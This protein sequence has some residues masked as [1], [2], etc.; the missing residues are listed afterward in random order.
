MKTTRTFASVCLTASCIAFAL[1]ANVSVGDQ[2]GVFRMTVAPDD[3]TTGDSRPELLTSP[4]GDLA[5]SNGGEPAGQIKL[6]NGSGFTGQL[7]GSAPGEVTLNGGNGPVFMDAGQFIAQSNGVTGQIVGS[8]AFHPHQLFGPQLTFE[9]NIDD[10]LGMPNSFTRFNAFIPNHLVDNTTILAATVSASLTDEGDDLYNYGAIL[11]HFDQS[12]N[13][14]WGMNFFGD[15]DSTGQLG[16]YYTRAGFGL[17]Y[18][19]RYFDF[20]VNGYVNTGSDG[21]LSSRTPISGLSLLGNN[22]VR[23]FSETREN[24]YQGVDWKIGTPIPWL[25]KRGAKTFLG[26][27][28][29][30]SEFGTKEALGLSAQF[31][32]QFTESVEANV[33]YTNDEVFGSNSWVNIAYILPNARQRRV[34]RPL[35]V[36]ERLTDP[37]RR[38]NPIHTKVERSIVTAAEINPDTGLPWFLNF[39]DPNATTDGQ[40]TVE[41]PFRTLEMAAAANGATVDG[42]RITP[43]VDET[44]TNLTVDGGLDLFP[45]QAIFSSHKDFVLFVDAGTPF[46]IPAAST[47]AAGPLISNPTITAGGSVLRIADGVRVNGLQI[48]AADEMGTDF[49]LGIDAPAPFD[50]ILLSSNTFTNYTI[51]ANL[52]GASGALLFDENTFSGLAGVSTDGLMVTTTVGSTS[53][54]RVRE[55]TATNNSSAGLYVRAG[56]GSTI[57]ADNPLGFGLLPPDPAAPPGPGGLPVPVFGPGAVEATGIVDNQVS[58]G[59]DGIVVIADAGATIDVVVEGNTS[60]DNTFNGFIGRADGGTIELVSMRENTF[61][62]N[63]ETGALLNFLNG[64]TITSLT[65][66][67]NGDGILNPS[68]DTNG[69]GI[70]DPAEDINGNGIL[71]PGEDTNGNGVLDPAEDLDGDG[72]IAAAED[73]NGN[74]LLDQGIVMNTMNDNGVVGLCLFGEDAS[75]G[76]FDIGGPFAGLGNT[77]SGN[78]GAGI[79]VDLQDSST[80]GIDALFNTIT[81]G[82]SGPASLTIVL[83]F[84]DPGQGSVVDAL[85]RTVNPFDVT[86]YGFAA[87]DFDTVTNAILNTVQNHYSSIPTV[88]TDN[89]SPIPDGFGLDIDF[90]IGDAGVAPSNGATEYYA[91]TIGD[92]AQDLGGLAGQAADI[93]NIRNAAGQGPGQGL[94]GVAQGIGQSAAAVYTNAINSFSPLLTPP[95]AFNDPTAVILDG[96]LSGYAVN[97]LTSGDLTFTR[98]AIGLVTS[99]ELGHTLSL[100]HILASSAV[101]PTGAAPLMATPA[102]D[103]PVQSLLE[104]SEF[105]FS[106]TNPGEIP[107]EAPF[108]QNTIEQLAN[109]VGLRAA[110]GPQANGITIVANDSARLRPSTFIENTISGASNRG[111]NI[112]MN[113]TA[114]A[115]DVTIQGNDIIGNGIGVRL[116]ANGPGAII[117]ADN[118]VG[119]TGMNLLGGS[120]FAQGNTI[121]N[122]T[123][124]GFQAAVAD[125]GTVVGNLLNNNISTNGGNGASFLIERGGTIDFGTTAD[126]IIAGNTIDQNAGHGIF[127]NSNVDET[128]P[129]TGQAM[130]LVIQGNSI[131]GNQ[132]GG[133]FAELSGFN[134]IPPGPP[135]AGFEENNVLNLTIGQTTAPFGTPVTDESNTI[136]GNGGVGVGLVVGGTGLANV[137]VVQNIITGTTTGSDPLFTG[138]GIKFIRRDSSLLLA[139]ILNNTVTGNADDGMDVDTQGTNRTNVN[140]P[141]SGTINSVTWDNNIFDNNGNN[142]VAFRTRGDSQLNA[143]GSSNFVR[144]NA[145]QGIDIE[146]SENSSFGDPSVALGQVVFDGITATN[147]GGDGLRATATEDS[148]ILF[149]VTSTL[150]PTSSGAHAAL[151]TNGDSNYSNNGA[152]GIHVDASGSSTVD[153]VITADTGNTFIQDNGTN[154]VL[155]S[156][157]GSATGDV[158]VMNSVITGSVAGASESSDVNGN[159]D[160]DVTDGDGIA[161]NATDASSVDLVVGGAPGEGNRIQ[162]N[163]DDGIAISLEGIAAPEITISYNQ[164]GGEDAGVQAGN[165]GDGISMNIRGGYNEN[166]ELTFTPPPGEPVTTGGLNFADLDDTGGAGVGEIPGNFTGG[167]NPVINVAD[168]MITRNIRNGVNIRLNGFNGRTNLRPDPIVGNE[169]RINQIALTDNIISSNGEHGVIIRTD[170]DM[171]QNRFVYLEP[172]VVPPVPPATDPTLEDNTDL[173][174]ANVLANILANPFSAVDADELFSGSYLN[175]Q[176]VQN[177]LL[178]VTDNTIQNNGTNTVLGTGLH[179]LVGTG[180]YLGADVRDN[181]FGG[182]LDADLFTNSFRST[183]EEPFASI[184]NEGGGTFPDAIEYDVVFLD[185]G[186]LLDMRFTD[187]VGDQVNLN[188][189]GALY[190]SDAEKGGPRSAE[191]FKID[192][193]NIADPTTGDLA[194][195]TFV[196][197]GVNQ[198]IPALFGVFQI[199]NDQ[200]EPLWPE[201]PFGDAD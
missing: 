50:N 192:G 41:S 101:T 119:G 16:D 108:T 194:T 154:G 5:D 146:T 125:G 31:Q 42:I 132:T 43:R 157:S 189:V 47:S 84:I 32:V 191:L 200:T 6:M 167:P 106:G 159:D 75:T 120:M 51:G 10:S 94:G 59:G 113:D 168:N 49:G 102:F 155:I 58:A 15:Y 142:G 178:T 98:R 170:T 96:E 111:L 44:G 153:V 122:G 156:A 129:N 19:S 65:E 148:D 11:R 140:Q 91:V 74:G 171:N 71:D 2:P 39:V 82:G 79:G 169:D 4:N 107:G 17:E 38:T 188:T 190:A 80:A 137:S 198:D 149:E 105:A 184:D 69:N 93:G 36:Q 134:N 182:N 133:I 175:L 174:P 61:S 176:T 179:I 130:D 197:L 112:E 123:G 144:N 172:I 199:L 99:H 13:A 55:N 114:V 152:N 18:L 90:V 63:L 161:Y 57:N 86:A 54:L 34:L 163:G 131:T 103:L 165:Q 89:R 92:S 46:V 124:D 20:I 162:N 201:D 14:I 24:V 173:S 9:Q 78:A 181:T 53:D 35:K 67:V 1:A 186:A 145:A 83:D 121:T 12:R 185:D 33:F 104:V 40:G 115:E 158:N 22:V 37:V 100:R 136:T 85:G 150:V 160:I 164:I 195:N 48:N 187:N 52:P 126:R 180:S 118:T 117:N 128:V 60:T 77:F 141:Q 66:D 151:N 23:S 177:T 62:S 87:A 81:G 72:F 193:Y 109:A 28:Y 7:N 183:E 143:N 135:A 70:L 97:A 29:L 68:E 166:G 147:N 116:A 127:A 138:D 139:D 8:Q 30:T 73:I 3:G 27:Y 56:A 45:N 95:D 25:G 88:G 64:G 76:D 196:E 21:V 26:S 110:G